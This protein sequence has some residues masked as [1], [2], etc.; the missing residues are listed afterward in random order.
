MT[1]AAL[2][3]KIESRTATLS[4]IGL[5]Y[6][7]LPLAVGFAKEG[8]K[9]IGIDLDQEKIR[10]LNAGVSYIPDITTDEVKDLVDR[11]LLSATDDF[12]ILE[13]VDA[14]SICVPT[15]LRKTKDPD[16]SY[17]IAA[18]EQIE[19]YSH[20]GLLI[21]LESTTY[22]GTT[23][24]LIIPQIVRNGYKIGEDVFICFSPERIDP[25]N[26]TYGV[27]NTPKIIGGATPQCT[28]VAVALYSKAI[29]QVVPVSSTRAA[30]MVKLLENTFRSVN[31]G[32][33]NEMALMCDKLDVNV[34][35]VIDAASTKPFG[36]MTFYPGPGLGGHCIP[37]DPLYLSWKLKTLNY[38][39]RFI[40]LA[41][42]INSNMPVYVVGKVMDALNEIRKPVNGSKVLILGVAYKRDINDLR[43]SPA[44]DV[45]RLLGDRGAEVS[46]HDPYV[47]DLHHESMPLESV[48]LTADALH[49]ADCVVIVTDHTSFDYNWIATESAVIV[50]SR[51]AL[52]NVSNPK[53]TVMGL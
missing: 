42:E 33:V 32:M 20:S 8:Y 35:E 22:P 4:V 16:M 13:T 10:L 9:V 28:E 47:P 14:I 37:I 48:P 15:P 40:E 44:L 2:L 3:E 41:S 23:D 12:S 1:Q 19:K 46:Y 50:D 39:A 31:I 51:N 52:K 24:E 53:A 49:E 7:G 29:D 18:A 21:V 17:I 26:P 11:G 5:G 30:E 34:W 27:R 43:E 6:V 38:T 45:I 25:G 36:F